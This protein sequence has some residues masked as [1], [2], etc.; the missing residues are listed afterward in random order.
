MG[1]GHSVTP[2]LPPTTTTTTHTQLNPKIPTGEPAA[3]ADRTRRKV[4]GAES[5]LKINR[6]LTH[7]AEGLLRTSSGW[8]TAKH[9]SL[10]KANWQQT[11]RVGC[12]AALRSA[13]TEIKRCLVHRSKMMQAGRMTGAVYGYSIHNHRI[14][15]GIDP[16]CN[17]FG[18]WLFEINE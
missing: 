8:L 15:V 3:W 17:P 5:R 13:A 11:Q 9:C 14:S 12:V 10:F 7:L 16:Q 6:L 18:L 4:G 1:V 2:S